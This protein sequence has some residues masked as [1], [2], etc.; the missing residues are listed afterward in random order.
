MSKATDYR[1]VARELFDTLKRIAKGYMTP[2]QIRRAIERRNDAMS[3]LDY[4]EALEMAYENIQGEAAQ[5]TA[6]RRRP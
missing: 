1:A 2:E 3:G 6:S 4:S 5:A